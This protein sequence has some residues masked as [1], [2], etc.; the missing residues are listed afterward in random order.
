MPIAPAPNRNRTK[1]R[2]WPEASIIAASLIARTGKTQGIKFKISPPRKAKPIT[3]Q[4]CA[5]AP[6]SV[7]IDLPAANDPASGAS[8]ATM[9]LCVVKSSPAMTV[10][11]TVWPASGVFKSPSTSITAI[12]LAN[13]GCL[14]A[15]PAGPSTKISV[16]GW[17]VVAKPIFS[18]DPDC[19]AVAILIGDGASMRGTLAANCA[20]AIAIDDGSAGPS[21]R[22]SRSAPAKGT[23]ISEQTS[24]SICPRICSAAP[25]SCPRTATGRITA[26]A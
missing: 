1:P 17:L 9:M 10:K 3:V 13:T 26:S 23:Q 18:C 7:G 11:S 21:A 6:A 5:I 12:L 2:L 8:F 16:T 24:A 14:K 15:M 25:R 19:H 4:N 20:I 22:S